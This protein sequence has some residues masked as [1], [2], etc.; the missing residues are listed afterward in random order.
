MNWQPV[1]SRVTLLA[2]GLRAGTGELARQAHTAAPAATMLAATDAGEL[3]GGSHT[4]PGHDA[5][6]ATIVRPGPAFRRGLA[7]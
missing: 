3:P 6:H 2:A 7:L 5:T 4:S 1:P